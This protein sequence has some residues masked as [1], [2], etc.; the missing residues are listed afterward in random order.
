MI[1]AIIWAL[2]AVIAVLGLYTIRR[3]PARPGYV[4]LATGL[5]WTA[6]AIT[7]AADRG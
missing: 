5:A 1:L 4:L 3:A 6:L 7:L 2:L